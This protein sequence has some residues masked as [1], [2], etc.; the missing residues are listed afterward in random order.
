MGIINATPNS[1]SNDGLGHDAKAA[2]NRAR[3]MIREGA[4]IID[5]GGES[6]RP[7]SD[8]VDPT[9]EL[10]RVLPVVHCL[11]REGI[12]VSIDTRHE[13]VAAQ[14]V[15]HGACI[16]NDITGFSQEPMIRLAQNTN[17]G[18][19]VMHMQGEPK[20]MQAAP[21][22]D[23]VV[24]EVEQFLLAQTRMLQ[25]RGIAQE[26]ICIDPGPGFGK[27]RT[28]NMALLCATKRLSSHGYPLM[29]AWSRKRFIGELTGIEDPGQRARA[30][31]LVAAYAASQGACVLRVHDVAETVQALRVD[32]SKKSASL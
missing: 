32:S 5:V 20:S 9:E 16:I 24:G 30:S 7:G 18:C 14:A 29:A 21:R 13:E 11:T 8:E 10:K 27:D 3:Q 22:Y 31:A 17:V 28:H 19:I 26:R 23:D 6:T 2:C 12:A 25:E 4:T 15:E 1:F